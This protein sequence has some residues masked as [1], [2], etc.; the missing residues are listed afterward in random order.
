M[1]PSTEYVPGLIAEQG[2][3]MNAHQTS[4]GNFRV[5]INGGEMTARIT[6][7]SGTVPEDAIVAAELCRTFTE[8]ENGGIVLQDNVLCTYH[9]LVI[10]GM[11]LNV[12]PLNNPHDANLVQLY[13][14]KRF[15]CTGAKVSIENG[16]TTFCGRAFSPVWAQL[17]PQAVFPST[18]TTIDSCDRV[19]LSNGAVLC[20]E[21]NAE[22]PPNAVSVR[23]NHQ[24]TQQLTATVLSVCWKTRIVTMT[25]GLKFLAPVVC[26]FAN[27]PLVPA[28]PTVQ[29]VPQAAWL[30]VQGRADELSALKK[31]NAA[32]QRL[33]TQEWEQKLKSVRKEL[34]QTQRALSK[35][36]SARQ[37]A[38][39]TVAETERALARKDDAHLK[40]VQR[41]QSRHGQELAELRRT[42]K[43]PPPKK[44]R[45]S[46]QKPL[47]KCEVCGC[48]VSS[49]VVVDQVPKSCAA[50]AGWSPWDSP[51]M[52]S[53]PF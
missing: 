30:D 52:V 9:H 51:L 27:P 31:A 20:N 3:V 1:S 41:L 49:A 16:I 50:D 33:A 38:L 6:E 39:D 28:S 45:R 34:A 13:P 48:V 11:H 26:S 46:P 32:A 40:E 14:T 5:G 37:Q 2:V 8:N 12:V 15:A 18:V 4:N 21:P 7:V 22:P 17:P 36:Q 25:G 47:Q 44:R 23:T 53:L 43:Q 19:T 29:L 42:I 10:P 35:A 24:V